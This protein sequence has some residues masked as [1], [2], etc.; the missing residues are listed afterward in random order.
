MVSHEERRMERINII[1][2]SVLNSSEEKVGVSKEKLVA[3]C[4]VEW[5]TTRRTALEYINQLLMSERIYEKDKLL[6][7]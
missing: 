4:C 7:A 6:W 5:G 2:N 3:W 1:R